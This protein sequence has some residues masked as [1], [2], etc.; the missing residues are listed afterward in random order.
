MPT[1]SPNTQWDPHSGCDLS[2]ARLGGRG[3]AT[4]D[5]CC[6]CTFVFT[7]DARGSF[8][9]WTQAR[10]SSLVGCFK[11]STNSS[12]LH[13]RQSVSCRNITRKSARLPVPQSGYPDH[14]NQAFAFSAILYPASHRRSLR[15]A[16]RQRRRRSGLPRSGPI[17]GSVRSR[18]DA[19]GHSSTMP[20]QKYG[21]PTTYLLVTACQP[22]TLFSL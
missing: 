22:L 20:D 17:T 1:R 10:A 15:S 4:Y 12:F 16:F 9:R 5:C 14:Y 21:I 11:F 3:A 6:I 7:S 13:R 2:T 18:L 19:G 8:H